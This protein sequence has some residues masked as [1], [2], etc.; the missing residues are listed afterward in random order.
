MR[1]LYQVVHRGNTHFWEKKEISKSNKIALRNKVALKL[2]H[3]ILGD[4]STRP[5]MAGDTANF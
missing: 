1:L 2:L 3:H 5:F 4:R